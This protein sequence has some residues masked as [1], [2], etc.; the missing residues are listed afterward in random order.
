MKNK[1]I[2]IVAAVA[3]AGLA[4]VA[5]AIT[6]PTTAGLFIVDDATSFTQ[7]VPITGGTAS[8]NGAFDAN[9]NVVITTGITVNGGGNPSIDL[10]V[11]TV[12]VGTT[13][14]T[15]SIYYSDVGF[16]PSFGKGYTLSTFLALGGPVSTSAFL[17]TAAFGQTT[18]LGG[19]VDTAGA[20]VLNAIGNISTASTYALTIRDVI[21]GSLTSMDTTLKVPDGGT[22]V[23]LL[24][25][26]LSGIGLLKKKLA[27]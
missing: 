25:M 5:S 24:G 21:S 4:Q 2:P 1:I 16:G 15:L 13:G 19:S 3:V 12:K 20:F 18:S 23:M 26:A 11:S 22:T 9:W 7:Y 17:G 10:D 6:F 27:A 8:F 14:T